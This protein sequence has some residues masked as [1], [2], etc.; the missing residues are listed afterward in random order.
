MGVL[1]NR[2]CELEWYAAG[3]V[4][5]KDFLLLSPSWKYFF[6]CIMWSMLS[7]SPIK[8]K[9]DDSILLIAKWNIAQIK[10]RLEI[11]L[12]ELDLKMIVQR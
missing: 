5:D 7:T 1:I 6:L 9:F 3:E 4:G 2:L 10:L 12:V 11:F 8:S